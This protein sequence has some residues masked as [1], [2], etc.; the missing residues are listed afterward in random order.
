MGLRRPTTPEP[1]REVVDRA[2]VRDAEG[3]ARQLR[4]GD[5]AQRR[6]AAR[7]LAGLPDSSSLLGA[8]L[9]V[10]HDPTVR[11]SLVT[12]LSVNADDAAVS[13]LIPLLRGDDPGLRNRAID[14]LSAMPEA[15]APR[16]LALME[17]PDADVRILAMHLMLELRSPDVP[18]WLE[19]V[20]ATDPD[21]NVVAGA[22]EVLMETGSSAQSPALAAVRARFPDDPF[23][24]FA[25]DAALERIGS[26]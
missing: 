4:D 23:V 10:E 24:G 14:A 19:A 20:L 5:P 17:D 13:A 2:H 1:L 7:D 15:L 25:V 11:E 3:L 16:M 21:V 22:I 6:W 12:A 26:S 18:R 8:A 9:A